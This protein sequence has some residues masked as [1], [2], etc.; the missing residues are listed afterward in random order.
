MS[1]ETDYF[2]RAAREEAAFIAAAEEA[3]RA[4]GKE[5]FDL[6]AFERVFNRGPQAAN[7]S[8]H[9]RGYYTSPAKT[10]AAYAESAREAYDL[11]R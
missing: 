6:A 8:A 7:E 1:W 2:A 5:L 10:L 4:E 9:R 3:A 11:S